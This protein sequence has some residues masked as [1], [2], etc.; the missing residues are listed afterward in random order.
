M[1]RKLA[2]Y[3]SAIVLSRRCYTLELASSWYEMILG[4]MILKDSISSN[5]HSVAPPQFWELLGAVVRPVW[6]AVILLVIGLIRL[7]AILGKR[8]TLCQ[9]VCLSST[10]LWLFMTILFLPVVD[11]MPL[12]AAAFP[13][14]FTGNLF[15]YLANSSKAQY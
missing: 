4:Y 15:S 3:A 6:F 2:R 13:V 7:I 1:R 12:V 5:P 11:N 10:V 14:F 8:Y 9:N